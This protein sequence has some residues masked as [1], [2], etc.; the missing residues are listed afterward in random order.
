[1]TDTVTNGTMT[2]FI[3]RC[4]QNGLKVTPQRIAIYRVLRESADHP[5]ADAVYRK[6]AAASPSISFDTVNRTL[7]TF[8]GIGIIDTVESYAATRRF[9]TDTSQHHHMHCLECGLITDFCDPG[10]DAVTVP[11]EV[12]RHFTVLGKRMVVS[13]ICRSCSEKASRR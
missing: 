5:S 8:A 6:M 10:I 1:M 4:R 7:L 9:D 11:V 3:D 12:A 2:Q 13:G